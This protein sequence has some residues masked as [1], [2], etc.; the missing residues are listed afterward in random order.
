MR[1]R[2]QDLDFENHLMFVRGGKGDKDRS[3]IL[4]ESLYGEL[5]NHLKSVKRLHEE[6]L[7]KG[8]GAVYLPGALAHKY[9]NAPK[10][11]K[12]QYVFP[13]KN[14][15]VDPR[16]GQTRR[17]HISDK[18]VQAIM[19]KAVM[20]SGV[21][22]HAT[23]HTL[24]HSFATHLLMSGTNIREVQELLGHKNVETTMIYTHV[25]RELGTK[26]QSPLDML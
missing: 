11:W 9:P 2:V 18:V 17:H 24:R 20:A 14:L 23:V 1:L 19:R 7:R 6:D 22:K 4:P 8:F 12:W 10:E 3:T 5:K 15:S 13:A 26:P 25:M 21:E 16:S